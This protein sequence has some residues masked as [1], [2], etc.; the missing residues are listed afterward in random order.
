MKHV[1][2]FFSFTHF[3]STNGGQCPNFDLRNSS[4]TICGSNRVEA[5]ARYLPRLQRDAINR[6]ETA[7]FSPARNFIS[8]RR[9]DES[10]RGLSFDSRIIITRRE[11]SLQ[12]LVLFLNFLNPNFILNCFAMTRR[13]HAQIYSR[14]SFADLP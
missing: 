12:F 8:E 7:Q 10:R 1:A 5:N 14:H 6:F 11:Y 2:T 4:L 13:F 9:K 3:L